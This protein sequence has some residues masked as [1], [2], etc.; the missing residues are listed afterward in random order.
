[1]SE[2]PED[3]ERMSQYQP[4]KEH[5][6]RDPARRVNCAASKLFGLQPMP[7]QRDR[8]C[9]TR[10]IRARNFRL[11]PRAHDKGFLLWLF[12]GWNLG[13][14]NA[15]QL[16]RFF[17]SCA[18]GEGVW[19]G[20]SAAERVSPV[21]RSRVE[22]SGSSAGQGGGFLQLPHVQPTPEDS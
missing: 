13:L 10:Y 12:A 1:M 22:S 16:L 2:R 7:L 14:G 17:Q 4:S 19:R 5:H 18:F 6:G 11:C 21:T 3:K 15:A 9:S 8:S 20:I